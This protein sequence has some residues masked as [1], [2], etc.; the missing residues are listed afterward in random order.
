MK[1]IFVLLFLPAAALAQAAAEKRPHETDAPVLSPAEATQ[2]FRLADGLVIDL[3]L[4]EPL[5]TQPLHISFDSRGRL[6]LVE[7][8]Q[9]PKPAGLKEVS[10]DAV[11]RAIY[12]KVPPPPPHAEGSSPALS[13]ELRLPQATQTNCTRRVCAR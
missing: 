2:K 8:R 7:A 1:S 10:K 12:D 5:I 13:G 4:S 3:V 6:W 9:Y 11:W